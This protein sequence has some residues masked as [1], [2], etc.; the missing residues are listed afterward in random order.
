MDSESIVGELQ[1]YKVEKLKELCSKRGI[2]FT[3][4]STLQKLAPSDDIESFIDM[5]E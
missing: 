1:G 4:R 3:G 2:K 5:F